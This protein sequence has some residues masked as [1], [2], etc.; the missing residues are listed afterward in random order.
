MR[1]IERYAGVF[2]ICLMALTGSVTLMR[3]SVDLS[4]GS[5]LADGSMQQDLELSFDAALPHRDLSLHVW[6]AVRFLVFGETE[7]GALAGE[8]GW[9]FTDE[10]FAAGPDD[11]ENLMARIAEIITVSEE[12]S[13]QGMTLIVALLP[14]KARVYPEKHGYARAPLVDDRYQTARSA[15]LGAGIE[16][17]DLRAALSDARTTAPSFLERDTHWTPH[18]ARI[19]A[20]TLARSLSAFDLATTPFEIEQKASITHRGDLIGFVET[21]WFADPLGLTAETLDQVD[22]F[23]MAGS[24]GLFD[25]PLPVSVALVGTSYSADPKWQFA[26]FLKYE[27]QL[28]LIND[29][30]VGRGPFAPMRDFINSLDDDAEGFSVVIWELPERYLTNLE[31]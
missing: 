30:Q 22:V 15:L 27:A 2:L 11:A 5:N 21:G 1:M 29:A 26:D 13:S 14:D 20:Q 19:V 18:G 28:D 3:A 24:I 8:D 31:Y 16:T 10:E 25:D 9:L 23:P 7:R 4:A 17:P 12:L 6:N